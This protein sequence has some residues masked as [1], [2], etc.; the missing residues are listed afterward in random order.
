[1]VP[2]VGTC[3]AVRLYADRI[4]GGPLWRGIFTLPRQGRHEGKCRITDARGVL[5]IAEEYDMVHRRYVFAAQKIVKSR[6]FF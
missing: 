2:V 6:N 5:R 1:M 3:L 4:P